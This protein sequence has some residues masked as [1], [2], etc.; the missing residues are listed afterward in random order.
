MRCPRCKSS[1]IQRGYNPVAIPLWLIGLRELLCNR[2]GLEFRGFDPFGRVERSPSVEL[3]TSANRRRTP[4][5]SAHLP[6][7][8]HLAEKDADTGKVSY[9]RPS[10]G[11]CEVISKFGLTLTFVGSRFAEEEVGSVGR[12][13]F[14][15]L[16]LPNGQIEAV[17]SL[18]THQRS[19]IE[20]G[21][22]GKWVIG[23]T[24][25]HMSEGDTALLSSYLEKRAE[26]API[27]A[28]D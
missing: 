6:A 4:R 1:R 26:A 22:R 12:L 19:E 18:L 3:E 28:I 14:V 21:M 2:C 17:V 8:I 5:Y 13:L 9:S 24:F 23:A 16:D 11:H 25:S 7:T 10:R 15:R 27:V 20:E